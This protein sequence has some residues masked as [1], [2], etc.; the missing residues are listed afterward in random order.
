MGVVKS[1]H[2]TPAPLSPNKSLMYE[3]APMAAKTIVFTSEYGSVHPS[4]AP[5]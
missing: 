5:L 4:D 3:V 1:S 2:V